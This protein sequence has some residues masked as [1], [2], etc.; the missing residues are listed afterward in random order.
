MLNTLLG[1]LTPWGPSPDVE[2]DGGTRV[3]GSRVASR[4][5]AFDLTQLLDGVGTPLFALDAD[6]SV[7]VWN[8]A[9]EELTG[10]PAAEALGT[11]HVSEAFY[12]DGR[13]ARTLADKVLD[14]PEDADR[15]FDLDRMD[16]DSRLYVDSSVMTDRHGV[17]R[18]I[19]F[20]AMPIYDDDGDLEGV[21]EVVHERTQEVKET[22]QT[23]ALV[24]ELG[25]TIRSVAAGNLSDRA[26]FE[27]EHDVLQD[28]L[29][30]VL[31]D[32]NGMAERFETLTAEVD[33]TT[34]TLSD[35]IDHAA[36]AAGD[37]ETHVH[38]QNDL[39]GRGAEEMQD[40]SA[41]ME[42]VAA[43][44][45][46]VASAAEQ[47][48]TAAAAGETAGEGVREATD[49]VIEIS[50][51][52]LESVVALQERMGDIEE[53]VE[54]IAEVADQTNLL[55][56][57]ANI[58]A[59]R[60]GDAG[61]GFSVVA[62]EVKQL[63]NKTHEH[64]EDIASSIE[65]IQEQADETV[66]A[67]ESSHEQI[68][69][70]SGEIEEVLESLDEI[71]DAADAAANG[72][73]EVARATDSQATNIEEVTTTIQ[74]VRERADE[75]EAASSRITDATSHQSVAIDDLQERV[76]RLCGRADADGVDLD[77][78]RPA[79]ARSDGGRPGRD[80][81]GFEFDR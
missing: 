74:T 56:L 66:A 15:E 60:A 28:E 10:V 35:A 43:T 52:L 24:D 23:G 69:V 68:E 41:S 63:A 64:T 17:D 3:T 12:P 76:D 33:E 26:R 47:A 4:A 59:A 29:L 67:S 32:F 39:L 72:V 54:V 14:H 36:E 62:D 7:V 21:V 27:D 65:E 71:S 49:N 8:S 73:Q 78:E 61:A 53:V 13:R 75:T 79:T 19:R 9:I 11:E 40:L 50:D 77:T 44:S 51:E 22:R 20:N 42:E 5:A 6:G 34:H 70:A 58:E 45:D 1:W 2:A 25:R 55:A 38:E 80:A 81:S 30:G 31:D 46:E 37:I 48:R 16:V 18:H 57:N